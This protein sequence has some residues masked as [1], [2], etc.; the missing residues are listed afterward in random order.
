ML[1]HDVSNL[2]KSE[3]VDPTKVVVRTL[4]HGSV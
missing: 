1:S 4:A 2:E 3:K